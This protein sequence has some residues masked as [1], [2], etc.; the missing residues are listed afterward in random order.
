[1]NA[2][3]IFCKIATGEIPSDFVYQDDEIV[4]FNDINPLAQT[5]VLI[6]PKRHIPA[7]SDVAEADAPLLA[8]LVLVAN[9]CLE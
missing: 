8:R 7:L 5:H 2:D 9:Q 4:A 6:I 3:C 1:M